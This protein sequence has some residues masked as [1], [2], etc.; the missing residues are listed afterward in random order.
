MD[1]TKYRVVEINNGN[2]IDQKL[3]YDEVM[4]WL[5]SSSARGSAYMIEPM[6]EE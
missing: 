5:D 3:T 2:V 1:E 6:E 4:L